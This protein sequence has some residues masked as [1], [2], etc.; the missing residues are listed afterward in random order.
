MALLR[1]RGKTKNS[2]SGA[3]YI[4]YRKTKQYEIAGKSTMT[5][6]GEQKLK[7]KRSR[8]G[9]TKIRILDANT[10]NVFDPKTK[11]YATATI[12]TVVENPANSQ[13][14]RRNIITKGTVV[15]T[16]KGKAKITSRPGQTGFLNATLV[17]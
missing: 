14:V 2:G 4:A 3:R 9:E 17:H 15:E 1:T 8:G 10:V 13:Y 5:K 7:T 11:K 12:K 6:V 16:T